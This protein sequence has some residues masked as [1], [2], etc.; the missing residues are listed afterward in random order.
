MT[1]VALDRTHVR[2]QARAWERLRRNAAGAVVAGVI[3]GNAAVITWLWVHGG[4][5]TKVHTTG[6]ALTS[7]A[8]ITGLWSAYLALIQ[9]VLLARLPPPERVVACDRPS[10]WHR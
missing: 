5:V 3:V 10:R 1:E 4:N 7:I 8:R 2:A 9:V 6:E